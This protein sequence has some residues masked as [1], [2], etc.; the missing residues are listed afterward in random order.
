MQTLCTGFDRHPRN[1]LTF[2]LGK[3]QIL[4]INISSH[5]RECWMSCW[6]SLSLYKMPRYHGHLWYCLLKR[7]LPLQVICY[8]FFIMMQEFVEMWSLSLHCTW[9]SPCIGEF[10]SDIA[11]SVQW[12][13]ER[14]HALYQML[15]YI[16]LKLDDKLAENALVL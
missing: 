9:E 16:F 1:F 4:W 11:S 2:S 12:I 10:L 3:I 7:N 13:K 6:V 5:S 14:I 8:C 15:N